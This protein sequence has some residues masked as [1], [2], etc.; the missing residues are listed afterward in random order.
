MSDQALPVELQADW[1]RFGAWREQRLGRLAALSN[2][3]RQSGFD[4]AL[5]QD[6]LNG[7]EQRLRQDLVQL[8][9]VAEFSRGK[10]E[11]I[12]A[13]FFSGHGQRILPAGA[14]RTTMCP[15]E[16]ASDPRLPTGLRLLPIETRLDA[17]TLTQWKT[18]HDAWQDHTFA[19]DD[20]AGMSSALSH[21][22]D[23]LAV[24]LDRAQE[25]GFYLDAGHPRSGGSSW[26]H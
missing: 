22:S 8:A 19:P 2:W 12:N 20:A 14:G 6:S 13:I 18:R 15:M 1:T 25:L 4:P 3:L 16:L 9:F 7:L 23:T 17:A 21:L 11:L 5:W 24:S 26:G 10:S